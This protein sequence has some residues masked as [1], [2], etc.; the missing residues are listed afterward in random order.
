MVILITGGA[1]FIGSN[2]I[3]YWLQ[4]HSEDVIV[5]FDAL[6]YAGNLANLEQI[7]NHSQY[8]FFQGDLR[9]SDQIDEVLAHMETAFSGLEPEV[10]EK[11]KWGNMAALKAETTIP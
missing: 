7:E 5:N 11:L 4:E 8:R 9:N 10:V 6:T 2:L 3:H 1:G